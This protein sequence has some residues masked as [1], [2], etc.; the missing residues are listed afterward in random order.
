MADIPGFFFAGAAT[1]PGFIICAGE[2]ALAVMAM[3]VLLGVGGLLALADPEAPFR[4]VPV[5]QA[6]RR[7]E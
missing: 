2:P 3:L 1:L 4:T 5:R 6:P 7:G